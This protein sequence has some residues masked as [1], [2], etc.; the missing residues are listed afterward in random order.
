MELESYYYDSYDTKVLLVI[1]F[2]IK[3][4]FSFNL[5]KIRLNENDRFKHLL[6]LNRV[7][8]F[9]PRNEITSL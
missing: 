1:I 2:M 3:I 4:I 5:L 7:L 6:T 9:S 8:Q